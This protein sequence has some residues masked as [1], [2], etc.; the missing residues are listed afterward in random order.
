M[1]LV[2]PSFNLYSMPLLILVLQGYLFA[3]LLL[4]RYFVKKNISDLFLSLLL[5][6]TGY[7]TTTYTI[8]FMGWYDTYRNTKI[9]YWLVDFIF[10][11]GP[12]VY[13]Y[14]KSLT[15]PQ[16]KFR[17]IDFWHFVPAIVFWI[18]KMS[19]FYYD[20]LQPGFSDVQNGWF[21]TNIHYQ[22]VSPWLGPLKDMSYLGYLLVSFKVYLDHRN[23]IQ[24]YFSN[25]YKVELNWLR[26]FIVLFIVLFLLQTILYFTDFSFFEN[27]W[28]QRWWG[29]FAKVLTL[30]YVGMMGYFSD[31]TKLRILQKIPETVV[32]P[33]VNLVS[34]ETSELDKH[35]KQVTDYMTTHQPFLN[36]EITLPELAKNMKMSTNQLSQVINTGFDKNFN[37]FINSYRVE[38]FKSKLRD[39]SLQHLS[40]LGIALECGFNSKATFNRVF[41]KITNQSPSQYQ[42]SLKG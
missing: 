7:H 3:L 40:L 9:N 22:Y 11:V 12:L 13:F 23:N 37:E 20:S 14:V 21:V 4:R 17:K 39:E 5:I 2:F 31:F 24:Q 1:Y 36:P 33:R 19:F 18:Y 15:E 41:K 29:D 25:T 27:Y 6:I 30:V 10:A 38:I 8:G 35:K 34:N 28:K 42:K 16:F 26:N 32:Q